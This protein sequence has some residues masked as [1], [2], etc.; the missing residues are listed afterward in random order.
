MLEAEKNLVFQRYLEDQQ[1]N[2]TKIIEDIRQEI[3]NDDLRSKNHVEDLKMAMKDM[4]ATKADDESNPDP[5]SNL[6]DL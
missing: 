4:V 3:Q 1:Q 5:M 6:N 2:I